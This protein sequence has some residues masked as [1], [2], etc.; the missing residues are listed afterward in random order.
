MEV[1]KPRTAN[2]DEA[3]EGGASAKK[4]NKVDLEDYE[5]YSEEDERSKMKQ[6]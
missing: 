5:Y 2:F 4:A 1:F 3:E 6:S